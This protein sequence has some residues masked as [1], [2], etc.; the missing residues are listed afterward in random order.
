MLGNPITNRVRNVK[1]A[2]DVD[3][4]VII[5]SLLD[6]VLNNW[7]LRMDQLGGFGFASIQNSTS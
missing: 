6:V 5:Q 2:D 1:T 4:D 3:A 7:T